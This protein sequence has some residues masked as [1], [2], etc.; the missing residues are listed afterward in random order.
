MHDFLHE[1]WFLLCWNQLICKIFWSASKNYKKSKIK[2][3][4]LSFVDHHNLFSEEW[5]SMLVFSVKYFVHSLVLVKI[6]STNN[7]RLSKEQWWLHA[8]CTNS[9]ECFFPNKPSCHNVEILQL[10]CSSI[11]VSAKKQTV[12]FYQFQFEEKLRKPEISF[13]FYNV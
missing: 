5:L 6:G 13:L 9:L 4:L 2:R 8:C 12:A 1:L 7:S 3:S 10:A 11:P